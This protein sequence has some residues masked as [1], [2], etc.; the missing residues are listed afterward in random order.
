MLSQSCPNGIEL[1]R[2]SII[3]DG[4]QKLLS[5]YIITFGWYFS[6]HL[7]ILEPGILIK[8]QEVIQLRQPAG[9]NIDEIQSHAPLAIK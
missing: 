1:F 7:H 3:S 2:M 6:F 5:I 8:L 9:K 4:E